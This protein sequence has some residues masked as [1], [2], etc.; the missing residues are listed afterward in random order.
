M[1]EIT[2]AERDEARGNLASSIQRKI[3]VKDQKV[4]FDPRQEEW[5]SDWSALDPVTGNWVEMRGVYFL[6]KGTFRN[7]PFYEYPRSFGGDDLVEV[8]LVIEESIAR[9]EARVAADRQRVGTKEWWAVTCP[10]IVEATKAYRMEA[11]YFPAQ[12][13][14]RLS[15]K[16]CARAVGAAQKVI[17]AEEAENIAFFSETFNS[18]RSVA[19]IIGDGVVWSYADSHGMVLGAVLRRGTTANLWLPGTH[20]HGPG[21]NYLVTAANDGTVTMEEQL[22]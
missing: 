11:E 18:R 2:R 14:L 7:I 22:L 17:R 10:S 16:S 4:W 15:V 8:L 21:T 12:R 13:G 1:S 3:M 19:R 6:K 9:E 5:V 20:G